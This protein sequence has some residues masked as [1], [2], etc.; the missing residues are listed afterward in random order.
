MKFET[1][2]SGEDVENDS[3]DSD[4]EDFYPSFNAAQ[5]EHVNRPDEPSVGTDLNNT[6]TNGPN[7]ASDVHNSSNDSY[8]SL[9]NDPFEDTVV[10]TLDDSRVDGTYTSNARPDPS[11]PTRVTKGASANMFN[12]MNASFAFCTATPNSPKEENGEKWM[13]AMREE[14]DSLEANHTWT[15]VELPQ[16]RKAVKNKWVYT[17]NFFLP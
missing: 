16:D 9:N 7:E 17:R 15:L 12:L 10:S 4:I 1:H 14:L 13:E 2:E 11:C 6:L 5:E 3:Y 8:E